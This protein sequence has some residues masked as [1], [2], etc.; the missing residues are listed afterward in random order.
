MINRI[1]AFLNLTDY[2]SELDEFLAHFAKMHPTLSQSQQIE[3]EKHARIAK[4]RDQS[5]LSS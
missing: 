2:T 1:K 5:T 4:L 3:K